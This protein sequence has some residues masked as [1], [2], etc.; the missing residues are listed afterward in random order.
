MSRRRPIP[1][2]PGVYRAS[3]LIGAGVSADRLRAHDVRRI[4]RGLVIHPEYE[5]DHF[6]YR[7]R[8]VAIGQTLRSEH[9]LSRRSAAAVYG[10]PCPLPPRGRV[11]VASFSPH[12]APRHRLIAGHRVKPGGL[13]WTEHEGIT[14]PTPADVWCQLASVV[15]FRE[16][17]A[18][19][20]FLIS[21]RRTLDGTG[22][23]TP[24]LCTARDLELAR[25]RHRNTLGA[26]VRQRALPLLRAPVDSPPESYIRLVIRD[27]GFDEPLVACPVPTQERVLHADLGYPD[28]R[29]AIEYEGAHH[30]SSERQ[31]RRDAIRRKQMARAGWTVILAMDDDVADPASFI[32]ALGH[33]IESA[34]KSPA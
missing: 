24:P 26:P 4:G 21:G 10:I 27:A 8:C 20:D 18:A 2:V 11:D 25:S 28:L 3:E 19:G 9:F 12:R 14:L 15:A 30:F 23:R 13:R 7:A 6:A 29:I 5:Y 22:G 34:Y 33:V 16:L 31:V 17:V 1:V 32:D